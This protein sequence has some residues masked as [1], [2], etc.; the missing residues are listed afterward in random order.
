[1]KWYFLSSSFKAISSCS[2]MTRPAPDP[3]FIL[4]NSDKSPVT[5]IKFMQFPTSS[6]PVLCSGNQ[7]GDISVWDLNLKRTTK[8]VSKVHE[9]RGVL[10]IEQLDN[11]GHAVT[12]GRDGRLVFWDVA[13]GWKKTS[14]VSICSTGF[15]RGCVIPRDSTSSSLIAVP[16]QQESQI[17]VI[18]SV[19]QENIACLTPPNKNQEGMKY[20]MCMDVTGLKNNHSELLVAYENGHVALWDIRQRNIIDRIGLYEEMVTCVCCSESGR[21]W[22]GSVNNKLTH[23]VV[24]RESGFTELPPVSLT[25]PGVNHL[26]LRNDEKILAVAGWDKNIRIFGAKKGKPLAVLTQHKMS[27]KCLDFSQDEYLAAGSQDG[28]ISLWDIYR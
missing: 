13:N 6:H 27:V 7:S 25:N 8:K 26:K 3:V 15:C 1:F 17:N 24:S 14:E 9:V 28:S 16:S 22:S 19:S 10:W 23:W 20:G 11:S 2:L 5:C 18:D 21:G 12:T 4:R